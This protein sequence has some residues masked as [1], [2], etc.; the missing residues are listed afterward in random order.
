MIWWT[1]SLRLSAR[2]SNETRSWIAK[3]HNNQAILLE[4]KTVQKDP[5][6]LSN[7]YGLFLPLRTM[8]LMLP[9]T[10]IRI[11]L[12]FQ[13]TTFTLRIPMALT[14]HPSSP[15][16]MRAAIR[17]KVKHLRRSILNKSSSIRLKNSRISMQFRPSRS[18]LPNKRTLVEVRIPLFIRSKGTTSWMTSLK[19]ITRVPY[20]LNRWLDSSSLT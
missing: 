13:L 14:T 2:G 20:F 3:H 8:L 19:L 16:C 12:L 18:K 10:Y 6:P 15:P 1:I 4:A 5:T 11:K 17:S 9:G 7:A